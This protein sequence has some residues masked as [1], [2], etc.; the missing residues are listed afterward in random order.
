MI[1]HLPFFGCS[2]ANCCNCYGSVPE[3]R[4]HHLRWKEKF[5][6]WSLNLKVEFY[7]CFAHRRLKHILW[8]KIPRQVS[9]ICR[10]AL[11]HATYLHGAPSRLFSCGKCDGMCCAYDWLSMRRADLKEPFLSLGLIFTLTLYLL[12]YT[13]F[14]PTWL[15]VFPVGEVILILSTLK[16]RTRFCSSSMLE[17]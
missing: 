2:N 11:G 9:F 13:L 8:W 14:H 10:V 1:H 16:L 7:S 6:T 12:L 4:N 3:R 15:S 5:R 17:A